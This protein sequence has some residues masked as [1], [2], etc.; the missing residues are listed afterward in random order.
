MPV[1]DRA[2]TTHPIFESR[3]RRHVAARGQLAVTPLAKI[4]HV[5]ALISGHYQ[6]TAPIF[7]DG[8]CSYFSRDDV[9]RVVAEHGYRP[10]ARLIG[11]PEST[12]RGWA[13]V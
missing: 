5:L 11:V 1:H 12:L 9:R 6:R 3:L 8:F 7:Y 2:S 10:G 4:G 13:N